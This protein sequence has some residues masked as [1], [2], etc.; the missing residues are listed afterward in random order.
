VD[1]F[2]LLHGHD[3]SEPCDTLT[4]KHKKPSLSDSRF[5]CR[6]KELETSKRDLKSEIP[7]RHASKARRAGAILNRRYFMATINLRNVPDDLH[8]KAKARAAMEG[9]TLKQIIMRLLE[10]YLEGVC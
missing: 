5:F 3:T 2:F 10:E 8:R 1:G 4:A 6:F 7:A 9:V